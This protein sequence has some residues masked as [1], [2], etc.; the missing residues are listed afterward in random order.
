M[1][2]PKL[3]S[4]KEAM[5]TNQYSQHGEEVVLQKIFDH[6]GTTNKFFVDYGA[7]DGYNL[8]N[9]RHFLNNGWTGLMMDGF[10]ESKD[11]KKEMITPDNIL[12]LLGKYNVPFVIDLLS[13]DLDSCDHFIL[14]NILFTYKPRV[15]ICEF[16][17]ALS[18][19]TYL[20]Y[21]KGYVW[22]GTDKY[23]FSFD[24]AKDI[25]HEYSLVYNN[26]CNLIFIHKDIVDI[27]LGIT[28]EVKR[29]H[30]HNP[31]AQWITV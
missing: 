22:D 28:H 12:L 3:P 17:P 27:D 16:N 1:N 25:C 18:G 11:V 31:K 29:V 5:K 10:H 19:K 2:F 9:T 7:G 23:G 14:Q 4:Q 21:E 26:G 15:I 8:S 20:Q 13:Q 24:Y 6:I 30:P